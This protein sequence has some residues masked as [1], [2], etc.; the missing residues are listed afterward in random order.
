MSAK[1]K[2]N[3]IKEIFECIST[4]GGVLIVGLY[5]KHFTSSSRKHWQFIIRDLQ[6]FSA[7]YT[8]LSPSEGAA[9]CLKTA[10]NGGKFPADLCIV[11]KDSKGVTKRAFIRPSD[12]SFEEAVNK[13]KEFCS[14]YS[15]A[16][17]YKAPN[18]KKKNEVSVKEE[19]NDNLAIDVECVDGPELS[20]GETFSFLS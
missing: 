2:K 7:D 1:T 19:P 12:A 15:D 18:D 3:Y 16:C 11:E 6:E 17:D 5:L 13:Y 9:H 14:H 10:F 8:V 4:W 20:Q